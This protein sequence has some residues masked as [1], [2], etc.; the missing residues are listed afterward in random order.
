MLCAGLLTA[1]A[2][3]SASSLSS[4]STI[5]RF[6]AML[7]ALLAP[8]DDLAEEVAG[9]RLGGVAGTAELEGPAAVR[10]AGSLFPIAIPAAA[11]WLP[12]PFLPRISTM[13]REG[14][15]SKKAR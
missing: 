1:G 2:A 11:D 9:S 15:C 10:C 5:R 13:S 14:F 6:A 7:S 4:A 12:G 8:M 3:A